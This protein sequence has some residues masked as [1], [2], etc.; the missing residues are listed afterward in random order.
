MEVIKPWPE[1]AITE[2]IS[3]DSMAMLAAGLLY[4]MNEHKTN[5]KSLYEQNSIFEN[6][7]GFALLQQKDLHWLRIFWVSD[8]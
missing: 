7:L 6:N 3:H 4:G 8:M 5:D 2:A 1:E